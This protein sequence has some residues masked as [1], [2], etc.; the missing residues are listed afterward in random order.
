M[1]AIVGSYFF[2]KGG[3]WYRET[4]KQALDYGTVVKQTQH[5]VVCC[6]P[7]RSLPNDCFFLWRL[8]ISSRIHRRVS[9]G[10]PLRREPRP[11]LLCS[12]WLA[13]MSQAEQAAGSS[14]LS[15]L[16]VTYCRTF[17]FRSPSSDVLLFSVRLSVTNVAFCLQ[18][19]SS[20]F[21]ILLV[22]LKWKK[23]HKIFI[24]IMYRSTKPNYPFVNKTQ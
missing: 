15:Q 11:S 5:L 1:G 8:N 6:I 14:A 20:R 7:E 17:S 22:T 3:S 21:F 2:W 9:G 4:N 12:A 23:L 13:Q 24:I 10:N 18:H 16:S 19:V